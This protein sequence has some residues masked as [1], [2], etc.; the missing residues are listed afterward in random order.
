M[1]GYLFREMAILPKRCRD[2]FTGGSND[3]PALP[4]RPLGKRWRLDGR[5]SGD[6][7]R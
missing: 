3:P 2:I 4:Q 5:L 1:R 6:V 7:L